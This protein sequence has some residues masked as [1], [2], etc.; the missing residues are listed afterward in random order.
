[1]FLSALKSK[2][3]DSLRLKTERAC[4][5]PPSQFKKCLI[6]FTAVMLL[7]PEEMLTRSIFNSKLLLNSSQQRSDL[8]SSKFS[9]SDKLSFKDPGEII[10]KISLFLKGNTFLKG[11]NLGPTLSAETRV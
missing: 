4:T 7:Y 6:S 3:W 9:M 1:M 2:A 11:S 5:V 8:E 10:F